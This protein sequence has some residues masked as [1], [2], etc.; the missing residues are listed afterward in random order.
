MAET[1]PAALSGIRT[2]KDMI[3]AFRDEAH[4]RRLLESMVWPNGRIWPA[5]GYRSSI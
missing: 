5:C 4:C 2:T 3:A 1:V